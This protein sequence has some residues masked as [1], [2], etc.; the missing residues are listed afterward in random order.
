MDV[1]RLKRGVARLARLGVR[2]GA[3]KRAREAAAREGA[4]EAL[5][6]GARQGGR[7]R[8][9]AP[10][11]AQR[12]VW[13]ALGRALWRYRR[14][15]AA[16]LVL[17][18]LAKLLMVAV[19]VALKAIVDALSGPSAALALPALLLVGYALLRFSGGLFTE[20]RDMV[21]AR[22]LQTL[23]AD[24]KLRVFAH[25]HA[26]SVRFHAS[27]QTGTVARDVERGATGAGFLMNALLFTVL[28]TLVEIV[29]VVAILVLG[30][31]AAY[32]WIVA[33]TF[34]AYAVFTAY[35]TEKRIYYQRRLNQLD[36]RAN[37]QLVDS[38]MNYEAVKYFNGAAREGARLKGLLRRWVRVGVGNQKALSILHVGQSG[39][40]AVGVAS[41][42]LMAGRDVVAGGMTVGDLVLINAYMI[43]I[44]LP[45]NTLGVVFRQS[46]EALVDAERMAEL[47]SQPPEAPPES[48]EPLRLIAGE[49]EFEGVSFGYEPGRPILHEVQF[50]IGSGQT[51]AVVGGSG[52]GKSTLARLLLRFYD[53]DEGRISVDG[54]DIRSV[55]HESLRDAIGIVPQ[56]TQLFDNTIAYNIA[57]GRRGATRE[58]V[59][60]AAR[61]ACVH[62]FIQSLPAQYETRVGE[63]GVK[64]S[65]GERQRIAI[66]RTLLKNPALL[67]FDEATSALDSRTERAIQAQL[68]DIARNRSTLIIAHR[69]STIVDADQILVMEGGRIVERGTHRELLQKQGLYAQMW[70]L[71]RQ[72]DELRQEESRPSAQPVNLVALVASV[73]DAVRPQASE[74]GVHLYTLASD[75]AARVSGDPGVLQRVVWELCVNAIAVTPPGGRIALRL[76]RAG[77]MA[78]LAIEDGRPPPDEVLKSE[79]MGQEEWSLAHTP[80]DPARL[81]G[82]IERMD[83]NWHVEHAQQDHGMVFTID[84]PLRAVAPPAPGATQ[85]ASLADALQGMEVLLIEDQEAA[86]DLIAEVLRDHRAEVVAFGDGAAALEELRRRPSNEWP[87]VL[88]CD[89]SMPELDGYA[90]IGRIRALEAERGIPLNRRLPAIALSGNAEREDRLRALLAGFQVYLGKPVDTRELVATARAMMRA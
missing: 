21:F 19:P 60:Q 78:R 74:K 59:E 48:R 39:V 8:A 50:R 61:E 9:G 76:E 73:L 80:P 28:P 41:I 79:A 38:L 69:L 56:D 81:G 57:Y 66:A 47:L 3:R 89:L 53:A 2:D 20:L 45:L 36:S 11:R 12:E 43:Q 77:N 1:D 17:L 42:M 63:R 15:T 46:R 58:Q 34:A 88:L 85:G 62:E 4:E 7:N 22:V 10:A 86:R 54:Q 16:A 26:L 49:V 37:G 33:A 75:E 83:G 90:V 24:F 13:R 51:V 64:L 84:L 70:R 44:C 5:R 65:G 52:S 72:Q 6:A 32:A 29:A 82:M 25:L 40:I 23:V 68:D 87:T 35:F 14:R 55:S 18:V 67:I 30:Y 31:A 27:R 71:Q